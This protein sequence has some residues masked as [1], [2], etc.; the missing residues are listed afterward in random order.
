MDLQ[1]WRA[2]SG[3]MFAAFP[4]ANVTQATLVAY[5][6]ELADHDARDV[7]GAAKWI[8]RNGGAFPP[9]LPELIA[10]VEREREVRVTYERLPDFTGSDALPPGELEKRLEAGARASAGASGYAA[11]VQ[12]PER[13]P[14]RAGSVTFTMPAHSTVEAAWVNGERITEPASAS[15]SSEGAD[16]D[17]SQGTTAP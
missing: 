8:M 1:E 14:E 4:A 11:D 2:I 5:F 7:A 9:S 10:Q 13:I 17:G 6:G 16:A 12:M 3:P 15:S